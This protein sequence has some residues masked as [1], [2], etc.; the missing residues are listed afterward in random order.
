MFPEVC[1]LVYC[2]LFNDPVNSSDCIVL[3]DGWIMNLIRHGR[4]RSWAVLKY[5]PGIS[6]EGLGKPTKTC[7]VKIAGLRGKI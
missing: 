4:K 7:Q 6:L 3:N 1:F 2:G 5:N